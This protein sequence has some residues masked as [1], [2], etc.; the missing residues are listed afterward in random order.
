MAN[1]LLTVLRQSG[2]RVFLKGAITI[3]ALIAL[4]YAVKSLDFESILRGLPFREDA[5]A[6]WLFGH[7]GFVVL[8]AGMATIGAPRQMISFF[9]AYFF[10]FLAGTV[11]ALSATVIGGVTT[12]TIARLFQGYFREFVRGKL[13]FAVQFWRENTFLAT[14]IV[15]LLPAGSNLIT[16]LAAGALKISPIRFFA[17]SAIGYIPQT[18]VFAMMGAGV[19]LESEQQVFISIV[20]F[21]VSAVLGLMLYARYRKRLKHSD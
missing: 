19:N 8:T 6:G 20:L 18:V 16:N 2:G 7:F 4:G 10:G 12:Y 1:R 21:V 11:L 15:R 3:I 5:G 14:L 17:G 9:A 13:V